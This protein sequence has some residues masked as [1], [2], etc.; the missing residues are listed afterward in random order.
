MSVSDFKQNVTN[1]FSKTKGNKFLPQNQ[2]YLREKVEQ[3]ECI[4][5]PKM[6]L[7]IQWMGIKG[8]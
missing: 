5:P 1:M 7:R 6:K 4:P 8:N 2:N 3:N